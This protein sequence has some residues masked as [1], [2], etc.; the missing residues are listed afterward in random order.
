MNA[1]FITQALE[2]SD[3]DTDLNWQVIVQESILHIYVNYKAENELDCDRLIRDIHSV[4]DYLDSTYQGFWLYSRVLGEVEPDWQTYIDLES[5]LSTDESASLLEDTEKLITETEKTIEELQED[6]I[7]VLQE[8]EVASSNNEIASNHLVNQATENLPQDTQTKYIEN[9]S[10]I[11]DKKAA[12]ITASEPETIKNSTNKSSIAEDVRDSKDNSIS[13]TT[14]EN[15]EEAIDIEQTNKLTQYCFI[16]NKRLLSSELVAPK[17][18]IA[19]LVRYFDELSEENRET[20]APLLYDFLYLDKQIDIDNYNSEIQTWWRHIIELTPEEKRK[21]AIWLSRYCFNS[22]LT[23][24]QI[25]AV[26]DAEAAKESAR[27]EATVKPETSIDEVN[28]NLA[29]PTK[30]QRQYKT[31]QKTRNKQR[32]PTPSSKRINL[33]IPICWIIVT[34]LFIILGISSAKTNSIANGTIPPICE[35]ITNPQ[36]LD[37]CK[38]AVALVGEELLTEVHQKSSPFARYQEKEAIVHCEKLVNL[39]SGISRNNNSRRSASVLDS[40]GESVIPGL[41]IAEAKQNNYRETEEP[42]VRI[43][44][45]YTLG[46][47]KKSPERKILQLISTDAIP[48]DWPTE[49]YEGKTALRDLQSINKALGIYSGLIFMGAGTL[50]T[51]IGLFVASMF[52]LGITIYSLEALYQSAFILGLTETIF[53]SAKMPLIGG[54]FIGLALKTIALGITGA[55]VKGLKV[56]WSDGYRAVALGTTTIIG[57]RELL[58]HFLI[59]AIAAFISN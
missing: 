34:L 35:E 45:V 26:F 53:D 56:H 1:E 30:H 55:C 17:L 16:R 27:Q 18:N 4:I 15:S 12:D 10:L 43:A 3:L 39:R 7:T 6:S 14:E 9:D 11:T 36:S 57:I 40:Y 5:D 46:S 22:E 28:N 49:A 32:K 58:K 51:A 42:Y 8:V 54:I 24:S 21:V 59:I 41:F 13:K 38:L 23:L 20:L 52:N 19:H 33:I 25:Q 44:C 48:E 2:Q 47:L 37:Y 29:T 31:S 50:F